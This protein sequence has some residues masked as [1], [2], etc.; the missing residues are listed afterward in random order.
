MSTDSVAAL[1]APAPLLRSLAIQR[2]VIHALLMREVI[3]RFGRQNL[4]VL[5]LLGEPMLFTIGIAVFWSLAGLKDHLRLP[6]VAF[7]ITGY[8]SVLM[9]RS[10]VSRCNR[11]IRENSSLLFHRN[12]RVLDVFAARALLE[13]A[14]TT[15]SF[16]VLSLACIGMELI[17]PPHDLLTMVGGWLMLGWFGIAFALLVGSAT[18][19]SEVVERI[20]HPVSYLLF[21]LSGAAFMVDWLPP[22]GQQTVLLLPMVHGVEFL[23]EGFFGNVVRTHHDMGY[24]AAANLVLMFAGLLLVRGAAR[25]VEER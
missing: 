8:S 12:V 23:R 21:P 25:R 19:Y 15:G 1:G 5:W 24:M 17:E 3:T 13:I 20:W 10:T 14:G 7:A 2:R 9:W 11:A 22:A 6:I 18:A 16:I 4:G